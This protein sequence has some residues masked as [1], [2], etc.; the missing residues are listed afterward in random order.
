MRLRFIIFF[1]FCSFAIPSR[2]PTRHTAEL[3]LSVIIKQEN[4]LCAFVHVAHFYTLQLV[5]KAICSPSR[6]SEEDEYISLTNLLQSPPLS[7]HAVCVDCSS[8]TCTHTSMLSPTQRQIALA[9]HKLAR[10]NFLS[11]DTGGSNMAAHV[12]HL[13]PPLFASTIF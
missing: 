13:L 10:A 7:D 8:Y 5:Q 6:R 3:Q 1:F 12:L 9:R 4:I 2:Y 11:D